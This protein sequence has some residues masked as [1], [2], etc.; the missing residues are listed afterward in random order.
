VTPGELCPRT[1]LLTKVLGDQIGHYLRYN[2]K[3]PTCLLYCFYGLAFFAELS[4]ISA[5]KGSFNSDTRFRTTGNPPRV[6]SDTLRGLRFF[7]S[8]ATEGGTPI[9]LKYDRLSPKESF[10]RG[11]VVLQIHNEKIFGRWGTF[12]N[13]VVGRLNLKDPRYAYYLI[14]GVKELQSARGSRLS[15]TPDQRATDPSREKIEE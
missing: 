15:A 1:Y 12:G 10:G 13:C 6:H 9:F 4:E 3:Y 2:S 11:R 8:A 7:V 5:Q 14:D